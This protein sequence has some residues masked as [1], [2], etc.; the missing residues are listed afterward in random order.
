[1][2]RAFLDIAPM[3]E[4]HWTGIPVVTAAL[5]ERAMADP[6]VDWQFLY[7]TIKLD[8]AT[9]ARLLARRSGAGLL[10]VLEGQL[11]DRQMLTREEAQ[12]G[13][14]IFP[15]LK[16]VRRYFQREAMI[17]HDFSTLLTPAFHNEDT[18][19][20]HTQGIT[21]DIATSDMNFCVSRSTAEDLRAYFRPP[22]D[23]I[24]VLP[25]GVSIDPSTLSQLAG[26][27]EAMSCEPYICVL[28]TLEPRKNAGIIFDFVRRLPDFLNRYRFVFVGR[29]GWLNE[30]ARLL[31]KIAELQP[32]AADRMVFSGFVP[33]STKLALLHFSQFVV[34][35]SIF[36]GYGIPVAEAG[37]LGKFVVCANTSSLPE[38]Y[39]ERSVFYDPDRPE[40]F[41]SAMKKAE[42]ASQITF[43]DR[44]PLS[45]ISGELEARSWDRTYG[46]VRDWLVQG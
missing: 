44:R 42:L 14:A 18:I 26:R 4:E 23:Q 6:G 13:A 22:S 19:N 21:D 24:A 5:A 37:V 46:A 38:V 30:K 40:S 7:E 8:R 9:V 35:P 3:F 27:G 25:M 17:H 34:Y 33:E 28:G 29:D 31:A 10:G 2:T 43:L 41:V 12:T 1:M 45:E 20:H 32:G 16:T 39:P 36:E 15:N 11:W